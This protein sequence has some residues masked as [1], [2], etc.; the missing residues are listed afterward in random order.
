MQQNPYSSFLFV[1]AVFLGGL[2][3]GRA[4]IGEKSGGRY[5]GG[6]ETKKIEA[7]RKAWSRYRGGREMVVFIL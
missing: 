7:K 2:P 5:R 1:L 4:V 6:R 3:L